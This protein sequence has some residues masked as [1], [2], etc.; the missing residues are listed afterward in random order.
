[1]PGWEGGVS[2]GDRGCNCRQRGCNHNTSHLL[3]RSA[4]LGKGIGL[5]TGSRKVA[6]IFYPGTRGS[7]LGVAGFL[8]TPYIHI[9]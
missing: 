8:Y 5:Q 2:V 3:G 9:E 7:T 1:M 4:K 6:S